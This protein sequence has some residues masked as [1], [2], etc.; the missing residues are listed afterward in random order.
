M[1]TFVRVLP[2]DKY[3]QI[4]ELRAKKKGNGPM[5]IDMPGMEHEHE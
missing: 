4:M 1:M 5:K 2:Q 3:D